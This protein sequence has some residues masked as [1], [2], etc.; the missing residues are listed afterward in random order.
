MVLFQDFALDGLDLTDDAE[1]AEDVVCLSQEAGLGVDIDYGLVCL[2]NLGF[3][4]GAVRRP[5]LLY[6]I[7]KLLAGGKLSGCLESVRMDAE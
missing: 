7:G 4:G 2:G 5:D 3:V 1:I 6:K